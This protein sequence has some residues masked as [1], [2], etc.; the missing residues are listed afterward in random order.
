MSTKFLA[1]LLALLKDPRVA[2]PVATGVGTAVVA[3]GTWFA[4][5]SW[6]V[7]IAVA[8]AIALVVLIL[9]LLRTLRSEE[10]DERLVGGL[11]GARSREVNKGEID[12]SGSGIRSEFEAA[13]GDIRGSRLGASGLHQLPWWLFLGSNGSGKTALIRSAGLEVPAEFAHRMRAGATNTCSIILTNQAVIFDTPGEFFDSGEQAS[14]DWSTLLRLLRKHRSGGPLEGLVVTLSAASLSTTSLLQLEEVGRR[15]RRR[16]N[17]V[18]DALGFD[19]PIYVVVTQIDRVQGFLEF[20]TSIAPERSREV[21]GWTNDRRDIGDVAQAHRRATRLVIDQVDQIL[22]ELLVRE[23]DPIRARNLYLF[24][25]ELSALCDR[26]EIV[27][28]NA[29]A[30]SVYDEV[31]FLR[32]LYF[33]SSMRD[34]S[35]VS[36]VATSLGQPWAARR[37]IECSRDQRRNLLHRPVSG[38]PPW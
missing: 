36:S 38:G 20:I 33:T 10:R 6:I 16:F 11:E 28:R 32:G 37:S 31:P 26:A 3:G 8:L 17:E 27:I 14:A 5:R 12:S 29:F 23:P 21:F 13:I 15:M 34:G 1:K 9:I 4:T 7:A 18:V 25:Q 30:P 22:T 19:V 35:T 24:P 2:L